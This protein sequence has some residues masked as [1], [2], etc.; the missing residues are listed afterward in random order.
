MDKNSSNK[1]SNFFKKEGIYV[2]VF[3]C[4]CI[5]ATFAAITARDSKKI[6]TQPPVAKEEKVIDVNES[7]DSALSSQ[8]LKKEK[9][10]VDNATQVKKGAASK[11][12]SN[13]KKK[14]A[15]VSANT[16][17]APSFNQLPV[18]GSLKQG[19]SENPILVE[20]N[21][22]AKQTWRDIKGMYINCKIGQ[23]VVAVDK[24][25]VEKTE[26]DGIEGMTVVIKHSNGLSTVYSNLDSKISVSKGKSV[27]KGEKI[28]SIGKTATQYIA[29]SDLI[30]GFLHFQVLEEG[31]STDP[32][33]FGIKYEKSK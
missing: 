11:T 31:N 29:Y 22:G 18:V 7:K 17:V 19:H 20:N 4:L 28:G 10:K 8:E 3:V 13:V 1:T 16:K 26:N 21:R 25:V 14:T 33:K 32:A 15:A 12:A 6:K 9:T 30:N 2:L 23:P 5:V 27:E 24:G